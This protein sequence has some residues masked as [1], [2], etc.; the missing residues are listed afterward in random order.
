MS[1]TVRLVA[2]S[3]ALGL[4]FTAVAWPGAGAGSGFSDWAVPTNLGP[5]VNSAFQDF[6]PAISKDRLSLYFTSDRPGGL[7]AP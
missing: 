6:G 4:A 3:I 5:T 2:A 1:L 7:A